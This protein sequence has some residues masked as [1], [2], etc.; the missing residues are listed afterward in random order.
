MFGKGEN[1][2]HGS[3]FKLQKPNDLVGFTQRGLTATR[4]IAEM[5]RDLNIHIEH[6]YLILNRLPA[7]AIPPLLQKAA[8]ALGV[9]LLG[10][11]PA[12][13]DLTEFEFSGRPLVDLPDDSP[14]YRAVAGMLRQIL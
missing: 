4:R 3:F 1:C 2:G 12:D 6:A 7:G 9:P 13:A 5:S 10:V 8:A 11:I 14:V